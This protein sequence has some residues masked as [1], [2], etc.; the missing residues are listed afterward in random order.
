[1]P[2]LTRRMQIQAVADRLAGLK[3][4]VKSADL[5][6]PWRTCYV[7][8]DTALPG[9]EESAMIN[10][11]S[12]RDDR[13]SIVAAI[14]EA[15]PGGGPTYHSLRAVADTM[16]PITW[17]WR[18]WIPRGMLSLMGGVPGSGKS[19]V[20]LDLARC[21]VDGLPFPDGADHPFSGANV[22]YV[23]AEAV[24]Q[25][26]NARAE[27]WNMNRDRIFLMLPETMTMIDFSRR[28]HQEQLLDMMH[29]LQPAL[30]IV[31]SLSSI[32]SK[33]ENN[34]EDVRN[35]LSFLGTIALDFQC[36]MLLVHHLRKRTL[37][38]LDVLS[39]EDFRG[40]SHIIAISR[41]VLGLSIIQTGPKLDRNGPRRLE[42]VKTNLGRYP[43]PIGC[44]FEPL[45]PNGVYISWG[46][47]PEKYKEVTD[48]ER[49]ADWLLRVLLEAG[50]PMK[51]KEII[52][53]AEDEGW[54]R[55]TVYRAKDA[56]GDQLAMI[57]GNRSPNKKWAIAGVT[58]SVD[59]NE[60]DD[61]ETS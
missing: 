54:S 45:E 29:A 61:S 4:T 8:I 15:T 38:M 21:V 25:L 6:E 20:A 3:P 47:A 19:Y 35:V 37:P 11:L 52:E 18:D 22:I 46:D 60:D 57:G 51:P 58:D 27:A 26:L 48:V 42:I 16:P 36:A 40:S 13:E 14:L 2:R 24:P 53:L 43:E 50:E 30:V 41:S 33:G 9:Q 39:A 17:F 32:S 5:D 34:V 49:C 7:A 44:T 12:S 23:D 56:L 59:T 1:M 28:E 55:P 31:D 10:A